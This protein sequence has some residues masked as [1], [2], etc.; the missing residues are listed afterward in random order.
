MLFPLEELLGLCLME[1]R[2]RVHTNFPEK[3]FLVLPYI[4]LVQILHSCTRFVL[5]FYLAIRQR[6]AA[7]VLRL[8]ELANRN[9]FP[10]TN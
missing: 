6:H 8:D 4:Q 1:K 5:F 3:L 9:T 2:E 10:F 7:G